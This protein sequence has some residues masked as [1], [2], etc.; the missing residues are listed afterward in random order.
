VGYNCDWSNSEKKSITCT[1]RIQNES[2]SDMILDIALESVQA[3]DGYGL[4]KNVSVFVA[5]QQVGYSTK[6][7][8]LKSSATL[9]IKIVTDAVPLQ[10]TIVWLK[11][12]GRFWYQGVGF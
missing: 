2:G 5:D 11:G 3:I 4:R 1:S 8:T 9:D 7:I 10:S 12:L 6:F